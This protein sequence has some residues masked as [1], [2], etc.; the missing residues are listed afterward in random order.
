MNDKMRIPLSVP[1]SWKCLSVKNAVDKISL[2]KRKLKQKKYLHEGKIPV[3]DQG[4]ELIGGYTDKE[5]M[6]VSSETPLIIF[7]DHTRIF[8]YIP[9]DFVA[10]ADGVKVLKPKA[11]YSPKMLFYLLQG[12]KLPSK[13]YARHFQY[14]EKSYIPLPPFSEQCR[15]VAKIEELFTKLDSGM[16]ALKH[17]Q[18]QLKRYRQSVLKAAVEGRLTAEWREQHLPAPNNVRQAGKDE[19]EPA[20]KLLERIQAERK[21]K[22]GNKYQ[23][24]VFVNTSNLPK[25][26]NK[27][28]WTSIKNISK[29]NPKFDRNQY[30]DEIDVSF[31]PMKNVSELSGIVDLS[32]IRKFK[33]VKKG[34]TPFQDNDIIFAKITPCMENGKIAVLLG[35]TSGIGFGS[36]EFHVIRL[37]NYMPRKYFFYYFIQDRFRKEAVKYMTGSVG[38]K[39]VPAK[40]LEGSLIPLPPLSEQIIITKEIDRIFS[41]CS[42]TETFLET[43]LKRAQSLRQ[44]ILK[45]AFEG[46]LVRQDPNDLPAPRPGKYFIYVLECSNGSHYIGHT[47]N[48]EKRWCDHAGGRGADWTKKYPPLALVHWEE[49]NTRA[50]AAKREKEL[51]TGFGRK[52]IK[53]EIKAGRARQAGEPA[54]I[55]LEKIKA[56][57]AKPKKSKQMEMF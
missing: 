18:A 30:S 51:K 16:D 22:L 46:K 2:T 49:Y 26:P 10:G 19:L 40:Y 37:P 44:S 48:I 11:M 56:E 29:V 24:P 38:Q 55:L 1:A 39:R 54:A 9:F 41:T 33:D 6:K 45:R 4:Q 57:K 53:R 21:A 5:E 15:I 35:L 47:E 31:I 34:Y 23:E 3:V 27:W 32:D 7:G 43:E 42:E 50:D 20:D 12:V 13:G 52:W 25:L 8:K 28:I 17:V 14:L 36:T